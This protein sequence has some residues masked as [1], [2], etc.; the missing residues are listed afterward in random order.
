MPKNAANRVRCACPQAASE[1][2]RRGAPPRR[3]PSERHVKRQAKKRGVR[4]RRW[5]RV[6]AGCR[7]RRLCRRR[8]L[9][10][11]AF[12][13]RRDRGVGCRCKACPPCRRRV[14][15]SVRRMH[16]HRSSALGYASAAFQRRTAGCTVRAPL[17]RRRL[18]PH[19]GLSVGGCIR[20]WADF[21]PY[22]VQVHYSLVISHYGYGK[23]ATQFCIFHIFHIPHAALNLL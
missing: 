15:R 8:C 1:A 22:P 16:P 6:A 9:P 10:S 19:S 23:A 13:P 3:A 4:Q 12:P 11:R 14:A 18:K 7:L 20:A 5:R 17:K 2:R 21:R